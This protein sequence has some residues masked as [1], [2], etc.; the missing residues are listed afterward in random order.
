MNELFFVALYLLTFAEQESHVSGDRMK[1]VIQSEPWS[2][3]AMEIARWVTLLPR[4]F[5]VT[6]ISFSLQR[7]QDTKLNTHSPCQAFCALNADQAVHQHP[8]TDRRKSM[9]C[10]RWYRRACQAV[11]HW[12]SGQAWGYLSIAH[13]LSDRWK[14]SWIVSLKSEQTTWEKRA[15]SPALSRYLK[16]PQ[17][18]LSSTWS[19]PWR[20][21]PWSKLLWLRLTLWYSMKGLWKHKSKGEERRSTDTSVQEPEFSFL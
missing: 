8:A 2:A 14:R 6:D 15:L 12:I 9:A 19:L 20:T 21:T 5:S 11:D 7:Q 13:V 1:T 16:Q 18:P 10:G 17:R 3:G 4:D